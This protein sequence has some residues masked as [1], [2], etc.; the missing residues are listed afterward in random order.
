MPDYKEMYF[1]LFRA[2]EE[3]INILVVA[4]R[5]CEEQYINQPEPEYTILLPPSDNQKSADGEYPDPRQKGVT[6]YKSRQTK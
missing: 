5:G 4:Q 2:S 6:A 1:N 3:A